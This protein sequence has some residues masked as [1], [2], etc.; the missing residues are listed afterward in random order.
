[1][2]DAYKQSY[3][4]IESAVASADIPE[5]ADIGQNIDSLLAKPETGTEPEWF[6]DEQNNALKGAEGVTMHSVN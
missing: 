6:N 1:I 4:D 5:D 2:D 3:Q